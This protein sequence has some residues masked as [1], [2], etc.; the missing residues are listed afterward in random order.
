VN[1]HLR[2]AADARALTRRRREARADHELAH[3]ANE[4]VE[5]T[6]PACGATTESLVACGDPETAF[7]SFGSCWS[8]DCD[9]YLKFVWN[10]EDGREGNDQTGASQARLTAFESGP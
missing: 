1:D 7:P 2:T 10:G 9:A 3:P 8:W 5:L 6:C 4:R